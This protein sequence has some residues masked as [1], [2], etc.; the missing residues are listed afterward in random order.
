MNLVIN[1]TLVLQHQGI[2][3]I[4]NKPFCSPWS[5]RMDWVRPNSRSSPGRK[6]MRFGV[7]QTGDRCL[8]RDATFLYQVMQTE[9]PKVAVSLVSPIS[10]HQ[11]SRKRSSRVLQTLL[12]QITRCS[13]VVS[14][15]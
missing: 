7:I 12:L 5:T 10:A 13:D 11:D 3:H 2:M 4:A 8:V 15:N 6:R 1:K 14:E 9:I